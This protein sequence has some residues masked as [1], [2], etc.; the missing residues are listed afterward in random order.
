MEEQ[1]STWGKFT[2]PESELA[3]LFVPDN[4]MQSVQF[5]LKTLIS[6]FSCFSQLG[7]QLAHNG[8]AN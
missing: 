1:P 3:C 7:V 5:I 8:F 4:W 6:S 2:E